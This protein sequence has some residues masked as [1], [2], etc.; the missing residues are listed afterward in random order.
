MGESRGGTGVVKNSG[1]F[2]QASLKGRQSRGFETREASRFGLVRLD[3]SLPI[4]FGI[5]F[6]DFIGNVPDWSVF[7]P[8][9]AASGKSEK[10][11]CF[12]GIF[13]FRFHWV[14]SRLVLFCPFP[15]P[16]TKRGPTR[17]FSQR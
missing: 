2:V 15:L 11:L 1:K 14:C 3:L 8:F 5:L 17:S 6:L 13:F 16:W 9:P 12:V 7:C 4:C 10:D